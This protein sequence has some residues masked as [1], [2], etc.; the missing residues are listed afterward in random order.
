MVDAEN[1]KKKQRRLT[2]IAYNQNRDKERPLPRLLYV[3]IDDIFDEDHAGDQI[4]E[5]I[6]EHGEENGR[7][8]KRTPTTM[9]KIMSATKLACA[10]MSTA[11][12]TAVAASMRTP[13]NMTKIMS[14][15]KLTF[16]SAF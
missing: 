1:Y 16:A 5:R 13:T 6:E 4:D 9:T 7:A 8:S 15:T 14:A 12:K 2:P 11:K 10:L 3:D